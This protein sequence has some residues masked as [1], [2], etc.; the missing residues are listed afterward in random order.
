MRLICQIRNKSSNGCPASRRV[1]VNVV[2]STAVR[3]PLFMRRPI[4]PTPRWLRELMF[5]DDRKHGV[6][7]QK[8]KKNYVI[9]TG[10][11]RP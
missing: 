11:N 8:R 7:L 2:H 3:S 4:D 5:A 9:P 1:P 10:Q 6:K